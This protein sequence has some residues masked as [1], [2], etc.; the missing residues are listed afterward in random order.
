MEENHGKHIWQQYFLPLIT[1][2][3]PTY[4]NSSQDCILPWTKLD[5]SYDDIEAV[6]RYCRECGIEIKYSHRW[7]GFARTKFKVLDTAA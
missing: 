4:E 6:I 2:T 3:R 5:L 1:N 7:C